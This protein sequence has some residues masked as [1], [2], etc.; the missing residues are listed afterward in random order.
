[1]D[2]L[3]KLRLLGLAGVL[4]L[5]VGIG[6]LA[7]RRARQAVPVHQIAK[8]SPGQEEE[9]EGEGH[10]DPIF[11]YHG[12]NLLAAENG[13]HIVS[14]R[15][16][17][18]DSAIDGQVDE[19]TLGDGKEAIFGF[20]GDQPSVFS[21]ISMLIPEANEANVKRFELFTADTQKGP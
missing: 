5:A 20:K 2:S 21:R 3:Q 19:H 17:G 7:I 4:I 1:M 10:F 16:L 6:A 12:V 18:W 9:E 13:G 14:A 8:V 11:Y 15:G